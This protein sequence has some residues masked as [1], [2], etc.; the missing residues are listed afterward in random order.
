MERKGRQ[1]SPRP[2]STEGGEIEP[3]CEMPASAAARAA[4]AWVRGMRRRARVTREIRVW[5]AEIG[6]RREARKR[7]FMLRSASRRRPVCPVGV[8]SSSDQGRPVGT[9]A[10]KVSPKAGRGRWVKNLLG[11]GVVARSGLEARF[12]QTLDLGHASFVDDDLHGTKAER[13]H[14]AVHDV[15]PV[16]LIA[17]IGARAFR[18]FRIHRWKAIG[19]RVEKGRPGNRRRDRPAVYWKKAWFGRRA[20]WRRAARCRR[21]AFCAG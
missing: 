19:K 3:A 10:E 1:Q 21:D 12:F 8:G 6:M 18:C 20:G 13:V 17:I 7:R 11:A 4:V 9:V 14:L 16:G 2:A 5:D 15:Q